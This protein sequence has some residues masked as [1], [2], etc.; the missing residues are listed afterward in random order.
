[1]I[2]YENVK[3]Q[4]TEWSSVLHFHKIKVIYSAIFNGYYMTRNIIIWE[5]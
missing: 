4:Q 3:R 1:M 5:P 2:L